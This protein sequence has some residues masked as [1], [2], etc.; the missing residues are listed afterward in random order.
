MTT[1]EGV[2]DR[3]DARTAIE[4]NADLGEFGLI[5]WGRQ[6]WNPICIGVHFRPARLGPLEAPGKC[7]TGGVSR[8]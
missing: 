4:L 8:S 1:L 6:H 2:P 7:R 3:P 5:L